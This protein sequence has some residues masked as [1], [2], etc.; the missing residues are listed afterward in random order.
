MVKKLLLKDEN[1]TFANA[2]KIVRDLELVMQ[3]ADQFGNNNNAGSAN[4]NAVNHVNSRRACA[5]IPGCRGG[6]H[7]QQHRSVS[8]KRQSSRYRAAP[9][10][11]TSV[12][13]MVTMLTYTS[14]ISVSVLSPANESQVE[15]KPKSI[16]EVRV[17]EFSERERV[18]VNVKDVKGHDNWFSSVV[19]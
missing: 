9:S 6:Y 12:S 16:L 14:K 19:K 13:P 1:L 4:V 3:S 15:V 17:P 8:P 18:W 7:Q 11:V 5:A 2:C 10:S